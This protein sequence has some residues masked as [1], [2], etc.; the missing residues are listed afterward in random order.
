[1]TTLQRKACLRCGKTVA[2]RVIRPPRV[3]RG[4]PIPPLSQPVPHKRTAPGRFLET[5]PQVWC[6]PTKVPRP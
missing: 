1:M 6:I 2:W 3:N 5:A 4:R